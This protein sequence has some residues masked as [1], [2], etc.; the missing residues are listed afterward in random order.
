MV[1]SRPQSDIAR[2]LLIIF[3]LSLLISSSLYIMR[4]FLPALIWAMMIVVATWPLM[5]GLQKRVGGRRG[6]ATALMLVGLLIVIALPLCGAVVAIAAHADSITEQAKALSHYRPAPPPAWLHNVPIMGERIAS[7]WQR[8]AH[9][10]VE[11]LWESVAPYADT[12]AKWLLSRATA[13][14]GIIVHLLLTLIICGVLYTHG[15]AAAG[16]MRRFAYRL[17]DERGTAAVRLAGQ[18][19]RAVALGIIVTAAVQSALAGLGLLVAGVP[20]AGVLSAVILIF[21]LAQIGPLLP[22]IGAA[23]WLFCHDANIAGIAMLV[24]A[25]VVSSLDNVVR[26]PLIRR[27]VDLPMLLIL[28]GVLGGLIAFGIVGLFIGPVILAV[29]YKLMQAWIDEQVHA[30]SDPYTEDRS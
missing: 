27:G 3:I 2:V 15:E 21:C 13:A 26:P 18:A 12:G 22:L 7:E 8:L 5:L 1:N 6:R 29:T 10:G 19:I 23:I 30:T 14:G 11:A 28:A 9:T 16:A 17:A 25:F 20:G 4:P 24:W